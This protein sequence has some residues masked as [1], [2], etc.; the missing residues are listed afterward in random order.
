MPEPILL[1][2]GRVIDPANGIDQL[3]DVLIVGGKI[4]A[5][6]QPGTLSARID[7]LVYDLQGKWVVPGLIDMHVHLREPGQ[8]YKETIATGTCAAAAGG[9]T[10]VASM[11]NTKPVNDNQT[12]TVFILTKAAEAGFARVYPVGAISSGSKGEQLAE[13]GDL[14][15][16]GA[17]AVSD[18]GLPVGNN[19]LM[20]RALEY[21]GN[22]DL[23]VISHAE[24]L[25][26]SHNGTMNYGPLATRLGLQGIPPVAEEI[27]IYRDLA[28][29]EFTGR[30]IHIAHVSTRESLALIRRAK[31]KGVAVTAETAPHYFTLTEL[32]V[33]G[34]N[35]LAKMNPPLRTEADVVA[36][37]EALRDGTLDAIATD[38]APHSE[39]EKEMEFDLAANGIIGL[40]TAVPLTLRLVRENQFDARR[41][42]ELLSLNPARILG[43]PGGTLSVGA[44]ADITIIDPEKKFIFTEESILSKSKNSPFIGWELQGKAV[45]T[46]LEGR[47][48]WRQDSD[49]SS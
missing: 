32:A 5:V 41:M 46:I 23:L 18:D 35:T 37:Q 44:P 9:F 11:P 16:A 15:Q 28:L 33:D 29:A 22:H 21:A 8:E 48:T 24:D 7:G 36:V 4:N 47:I 31:A 42:V 49:F 3:L 20:R 12:V 19:Q 30:P 27:M 38:H 34:Y 40:E 14:R 39:I 17:V 6:S 2:N 1:K 25:S 13:F 26:L 45:L 10:A 43:V